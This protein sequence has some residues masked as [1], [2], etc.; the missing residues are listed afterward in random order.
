MFVLVI[1][2]IVALVFIMRSFN[3]GEAFDCRNL[4]GEVYNEIKDD[5]NLKVDD[6][7]YNYNS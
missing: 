5:Y 7:S 6:D 4:V 3:T 1:S 2:N